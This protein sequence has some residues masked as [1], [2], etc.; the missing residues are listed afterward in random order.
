MS[1][2]A[3]R[4]AL[5]ETHRVFRSPSAWLMLGLVIAVL[6]ISGPF[7]TLETLRFPAR[8]LYWA[9]VVTLTAVSGWFVSQWIIRPLADRG[10]SRVAQWALASP[11]VG[12]VVMAEVAVL[13]AL[14]FG[15][16]P[17]SLPGVLSLAVSTVPVAMLVTAALTFAP[18]PQPAQQPQA[19]VPDT[20]RVP[21]LLSRLPLEKRGELVSLSVQDHYVEIVTLRGRAL[22]LIRLADAMAETDGCTGLQVHRSH[23]VARDQVAGTRREGA[24]GVLVMTDGR[25]IPVSRTYM[26]DAKA[27]GLF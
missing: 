11:A 10:L 6:A 16:S 19:A 17:F 7:G 25:E 26:S 23:W 21:R 3:L 27:A 2:T 24:R 20:P 5:R 13:N 12:L 1:D 14:A 8:L 4:L 9:A 18:R 22:V 15:L